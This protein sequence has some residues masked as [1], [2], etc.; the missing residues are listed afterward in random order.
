MDRSN[1]PALLTTLGPNGRRRAVAVGA[2]LLLAA[3]LAAVILQPEQGVVLVA[4]ALFA[5]FLI[6]RPHWG[7]LAIFV[8][9]I[10]RIDLVRL[11]PF[12]TSEML[13][14]PLLLPLAL[15]V[16]RDRRVWAWRIPQV[17]LLVAIGGVLLLAT[18]WSLLMHPAP[19]FPG[20][21]G[22]WSTL[23]LFGQQLLFLL[24]LVYFIKTP[25]HLV[26]AVVVVVIMVLAAAVDS[27]DLFNAGHGGDRARVRQGWAA[28]SNRLAF[29]CV[30]GT[31]LAWCLRFKGPRGWWRP[32]TLAPLLGLPIT[33]LMT[34]SRN[35]FLQLMLLGG[36]ILL[37]QRQWAP[38]QRTRAFA[39]T[40]IATLLVL[41]VAP[42]AMMQRASD[43]NQVSVS[44]RINAHWLGIALVAEYPLFGVGPG[45]FHWRI[46][47]ATG[48]AMSTHDAYLWAATAGGPLLLAL[49]LLLF[50]RTH[51]MLRSVE[52]WG[53]SQFAWLATGLRFNLII[54]LAFSL[55]ADLWLTHP[56][57]LLLGL[58]IVLFRVESAVDRRDANVQPRTAV[59][60]AA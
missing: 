57:Y 6:A 51:R 49:Y 24:Y 3:A 33:T 60:T 46:Q 48:R 1:F 14:A 58:A 8:L 40:V 17:R 56:F 42:S 21:D 39:L 44:D 45:N 30:W 10:F 26:Y 36:L 47:L 19:P 53:S 20:E 31:A 55:F 7:I 11:G 34:G 5:A 28:N 37:D 29:L 12:G 18:E 50:H 27:L 2:G 9:V 54:M 25:R 23:I 32:L 38:A 59:I 52:H 35:G 13:A 15:Q 43:F 4:Q 16:V 41:A 22:P